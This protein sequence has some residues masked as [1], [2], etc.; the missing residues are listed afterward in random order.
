MAFDYTTPFT[1]LGKLVKVSNLLLTH[2]ATIVGWAN[3]IL[4]QYEANR[5]LVPSTQQQ[6]TSW[7]SN[8]QSW[9]ASLK[10]TADKTLQ[11]LQPALFAPNNSIATILPLLLA[12]MNN[13]TQSIKSCAVTIS[14]ATAS[15]TNVGNG[16]LV[17]SKK[18]YSGSDNQLLITESLICRCVNDSTPGSEQFQLVGSPV[19]PVASGS[20]SR[21]SGTAT[22][23]PSNMLVNGSFATFSATNLPA[24]W[25]ISAGSSSI[26]QETSLIHSPAGGAL[27]LSGNGTITTITLAQTLAQRFPQYTPLAF[28]GWLR[29]NGTVTA[30]SNLKVW[31]TGS[32][33][34]DIVLYNA[35]PN[36]LTTSYAL[37]NVFSGM[38]AETPILTVNVSWTAANAAGASAILLLDDLVVAK[39]T[40]F[41]GAAYQ[42][43]RGAADFKI[44][45]S[46]TIATTND[47][48]GIFQTFLGRFYGVTLPSSGS[49]TISDSLAV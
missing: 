27:K 32:G 25:I 38:G 10:S 13:D 18:T 40:I 8:E 42:L 14:S 1:R 41:G 5:E 30:G 20:A 6:I 12:Q 37:T 33:I 44:G 31:I 7:A 28:G 26:T 47:Y 23:S 21:G 3:E 36:G 49:P 48:A 11:A 17:T 29:K 34:S 19:Q 45:D 46:F 22:F 24:N 15:G 39:P 43:Y 16:I 2:Q 35:D 9:I 4:S